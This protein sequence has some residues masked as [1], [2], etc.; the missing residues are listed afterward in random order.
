MSH[1]EVVWILIGALVIAAACIAAFVVTIHALNLFYRV[2]DP[3]IGRPPA[4]GKGNRDGDLS[5]QP[6]HDP[7]GTP[8]ARVRMSAAK[9]KPRR[10]GASHDQSMRPKGRD[11]TVPQ[12]VAGGMTAA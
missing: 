2:A 3:R 9:E 6:H 11:A 5:R 4:G 1:L 10:S 12:P 7:G 8:F